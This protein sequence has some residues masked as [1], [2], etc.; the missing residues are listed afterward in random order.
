MQNFFIDISIAM[1]MQ[2]SALLNLYRTNMTTVAAIMS[3]QQSEMD[4][5]KEMRQISMQVEK[6]LVA[7]NKDS[8]RCNP[9][10]FY[11]LVRS[12]NKIG[13]DFPHSN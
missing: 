13:N 5:L 4:F 7:R 11:R 3:N 8:E 1:E 2:M 9:N 12:N 10:L 6:E